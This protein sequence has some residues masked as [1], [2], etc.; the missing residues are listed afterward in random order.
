MRNKKILTQIGVQ[1]KTLK[2]IIT[3]L[4]NLG[5]NNKKYDLETKLIQL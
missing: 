4:N 2:K 3:H 1:E 5:K